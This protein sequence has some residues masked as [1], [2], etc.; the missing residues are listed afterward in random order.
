MCAPEKL[1]APHKNNVM[2]NSVYVILTEN[3]Y[4]L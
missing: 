1:G 3:I 4:P 2:E